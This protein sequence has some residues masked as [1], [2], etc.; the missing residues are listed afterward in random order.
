MQKLIY[1][2]ALEPEQKEVEV[3]VEDHEVHEQ[4]NTATTSA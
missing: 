3:G 4:Y 1:N 2:P